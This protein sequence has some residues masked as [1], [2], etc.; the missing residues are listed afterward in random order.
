L[1]INTK[2]IK[3]KSG[4]LTYRRKGQDFCVKTGFG[5]GDNILARGEHS[6]NDTFFIKNIAIWIAESWLLRY[7]GLNCGGWVMLK[8][9]RQ[10]EAEDRRAVTPR[11][12]LKRQMRLHGLSAPDL[13]REFKIHTQT[14]YSITS[15][16]RQI[17]SKL[18]VKLS[19]KFGEPVQF[20]LGEP[21]VSRSANARPGS[22]VLA[23]VASNDPHVQTSPADLGLF[24]KR[25]VAPPVILVD[26]DIRTL[27][28][29]GG[30]GLLIRPFQTQN[31][32]PASY[33]LTLGLIVTRGF[34]KLDKY[35]WGLI[36]RF[37]SGDET[38][39]DDE[40]DEAEA[41]IEEYE[42]D[43]DYTDV[44]TLGVREAV[45]IVLREDLNFSGEF[46][47][48][49]GGTTKNAIRGL[50]IEHGLQVDPGYSGPILV[51]AFNMGLNPIEL[52]AG[53]KLLSLEI[54]RLGR[55][56]EDPYHEDTNS[57]IARIVDRLST[58]IAD[59]F[60]YE[61]IPNEERYIAVLRQ[62]A[63][64]ESIVCDGSLEE[65]RTDVVQ[66]VV[67]ALAGGD[68]TDPFLLPFT[69]ALGQVTIDEED[70][71]ALIRRFPGCTEDAVALAKAAF[72]NGRDRKTL[73]DIF[74]KLDLLPGPAV[75]K[76][77]GIKVEES[78]I[79]S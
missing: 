12:H 22:P 58:E 72:K 19:E 4:F 74:K 77:M 59:L 30:S 75:A 52:A 78:N 20:W 3:N 34:A 79:G 45:G 51:T 9:A 49:V 47:A 68:S 41:L 46:L 39:R 11:D 42:K 61:P 24:E 23:A 2:A 10:P 15:G 5:S 25:T 69:R 50:M 55:A 1:A 54:I 17:S 66:R 13:A 65:V 38:L 44:L 27:T 35:D 37:E 16:K 76:L 7:I 40:R 56:P 32:S 31:V 18:A 57:K 26:H 63:D 6:K 70:A 43:I 67:E 48:R 53:Q 64:D 29:R 36:V 8:S 33:D 62:S 60:D 28:S 14:I 21:I 71:D 73:R